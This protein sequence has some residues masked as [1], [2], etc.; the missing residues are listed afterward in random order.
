M[1]KKTLLKTLKWLVVIAVFVLVV[2]YYKLIGALVGLL[3][4]VA[5]VLDISPSVPLGIALGILLL[6]PL[7]LALDQKSAANSLA[8]WSYCF[9]ALGIALQVYHFFKDAGEADKEAEGPAET[10]Q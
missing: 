2:I 1:V 4:I 7:M 3:F 10:E 5:F 9:L 6:A 8:T